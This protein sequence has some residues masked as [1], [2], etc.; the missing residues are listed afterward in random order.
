MVRGIGSPR[1]LP[2][3][4][5]D[6]TY[7]PLTLNTTAIDWPYVG[8]N[9]T[10]I[11]SN[12]IDNT[13][14]VTGTTKY[15]DGAV[16]Q[17][18]ETFLIRDKNTDGVYDTSDELIDSLGLSN[19]TYRE[20]F[21]TQLTDGS[22][23]LE[24]I[25]KIYPEVKY[26]PLTLGSAPPSGVSVWSSMVTFSQ[27]SYKDYNFS[28]WPK[29]RKSVAGVRY[30]TEL[31]NGNSY[32]LIEEVIYL[33]EPLDTDNDRLYAISTYPRLGYGNILIDSDG[34]VSGYYSIYD[35]TGTE[36]TRIA[37]EGIQ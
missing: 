7:I 35:I 30:Y 20:K 33:G 2:A 31:P 3:Q 11:P 8:Q 1:T 21:E 29:G 32:T 19:P 23:R 16:K 25:Y 28:F 14:R 36:I 27:K 13:Y 34:S 6:N 9:T 17:T 10:F 5:S 26:G 22:R 37:V 15:L 4:K 24:S 12:I 18:V